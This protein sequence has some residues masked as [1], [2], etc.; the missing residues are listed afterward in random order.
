[1]KR[2]EGMQDAGL[3]LGRPDS[4]ELQEYINRHP[5]PHVRKMREFVASQLVKPV[6]IEG[7]ER[8]TSEGTDSL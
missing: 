7:D 4:P 2:I 5:W 8:Q 6:M 1:M 3:D